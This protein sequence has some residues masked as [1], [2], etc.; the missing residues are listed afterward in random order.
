MRRVGE[1]DV[2]LTEGQCETLHAASSANHD[3]QVCASQHPAFSTF[4]TTSKVGARYS[5]GKMDT[6]LHDYR[7]G[8]SVRTL[9]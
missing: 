9:S 5:N 4:H 2:A 1:L 3:F 8:T 6:F 7:N